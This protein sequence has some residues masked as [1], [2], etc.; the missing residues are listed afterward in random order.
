MSAAW[1]EA[2]PDTRELDQLAAVVRRLTGEFQAAVPPD[3]V[4]RFV[5]DVAVR[6]ETAPV[7][8]YVPVLV[9]RIAREWL[10]DAV[11]ES[12]PRPALRA[13]PSI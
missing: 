6:F 13:V 4:E 1:E 9:E 10:R 11:R 2:P 3:V 12:E 7:R 8:I 5:H